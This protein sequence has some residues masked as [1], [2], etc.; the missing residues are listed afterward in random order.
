MHVAPLQ[1]HPGESLRCNPDLI[2]YCQ[3]QHPPLVSSLRSLTRA[4]EAAAIHNKQ[5]MC[6]SIAL[7]S[8]QCSSH[9]LVVCEAVGLDIALE[10]PRGVVGRDARHLLAAHF[11]MRLKTPSSKGFQIF[12]TESKGIMCC[13]RLDTTCHL[14]A[15]HFAAPKVDFGALVL[16]QVA[17][18]AQAVA[19]LQP[20]HGGGAQHVPQDDAH[21]HAC[22]I[23]RTTWP[24]AHTC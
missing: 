2:P 20:R 24:Q 1:L 9:L 12:C 8:A 13:A 10:S 7:T 17:R 16:K 15:A 11:S 14:L 3:A 19:V 21:R 6:V 23:Q 4:K 5:R 22:H 18:V